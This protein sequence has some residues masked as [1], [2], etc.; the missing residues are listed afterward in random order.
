MQEIKTKTKTTTE[1][2]KLLPTKEE[3]QEQEQKALAPDAI[4]KNNIYALVD[5]LKNDNQFIGLTDEEL[6]NNKAFFPRLVNYIYNNYISELLGNKYKQPA[7]YPDIKQIDY[8]FN[9]Y[10]DLI[11]KYKWNNKPFIVEFCNFTGINKD[12]IYSWLNNNNSGEL[13]NKYNNISVSVNSNSNGNGNIKK[14]S[15]SDSVQDEWITTHDRAAIVQKWIYTCEQALLNGSD[16]IRDIFIL[17][18]KH[19]YRDNNNVVE[20]N[21]NHKNVISADELPALIDIQNADK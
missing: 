14:D 7:L 9:I 4:Y 20:I 15:D 16:T 8:L 10:I 12:T 18:A 17:K 6:K 2:E 3:Q 19:N 13:Y 21:V 11:Y 1:N 5:D